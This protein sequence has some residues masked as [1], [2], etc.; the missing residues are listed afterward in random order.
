M[1]NN[2]TRTILDN[3]YGNPLFHFSLASK[4]LFHS[5]YLKWLWEIENNQPKSFGKQCLDVFLGLVYGQNPIPTYYYY[6]ISRE[7]N[8]IDLTIELKDN[9]KL[10]TDEIFIEL[11]IKSVPN[12]KQLED[13]YNK[14]NSTSSKFV[15]LTLDDISYI[16]G[17]E[18][19]IT[20]KLQ[21]YT[22]K[23]SLN[24]LPSEICNNYI[25]DYQSLISNLEMLLINEINFLGNNTT[26][27]KLSI[28][29]YDDRIKELRIH[30]LIS[31]YYFEKL[32][33]EFI[34]H[35]NGNSLT[36][37]KTDEKWAE[38]KNEDNNEDNIDF[39]CSTNYSNNNP[40]F[41]IFKFYK[42]IN[43][44]NMT[45]GLQ[46]Q[47]NRVKF[48][49]NNTGKQ[50][51]TGKIKTF[52]KNNTKFI[53]N[54]YILKVITKLELNN[55]LLFENTR[56][57]DE[58]LCY[59]PGF[60]YKYAKIKVDNLGKTNILKNDLFKDLINILKEININKNSIEKDLDNFTTP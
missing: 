7:K 38:I 20:I 35:C 22:S 30:D 59:A 42:T 8:N 39:Y 1:S 60:V 16:G 19:W 6:E 25:S 47:G 5:N 55:E 34:K 36:L 32:L 26:N 14:Y 48:F 13:Y 10:V 29:D 15:L 41:S 43:N 56:K 3:L 33:F 24:N 27:L 46:I 37:N 23:I 57:S 58:F 18:N 21:N 11:K 50:L 40:E 45:Y 49:V 31:K 17:I 4:E 51:I 2:N 28:S 9:N 52:L 53:N 12:I 44:Y 54:S